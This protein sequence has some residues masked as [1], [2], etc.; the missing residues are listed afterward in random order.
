MVLVHAVWGGGQ[1]WILEE[2]TFL[3]GNVATRSPPNGEYLQVLIISSPLER[4]GVGGI[5]SLFLS[6]TH[7]LQDHT[8]PTYP[9]CIP[10]ILESG[11]EESTY[12]SRAA[13]LS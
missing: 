6:I 7:T 8:Y 13:E 12:M 3:E 5:F 10:H 11:E 4:G 1:T 9:T 2:E